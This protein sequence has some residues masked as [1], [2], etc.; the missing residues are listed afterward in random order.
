MADETYQ[1]PPGPPPSYRPQR[2]EPQ[3]EEQY[4]PPPGPPPSQRGA[5]ITF[6]PPARPEPSSN[7]A[8]PS[9]PPPSYAMQSQ[10]LAYDYAP[11]QGPPPSRDD[12]SSK[13]PSEKSSTAEP[14]PYHDWTVIPDTSLL[15]P[16]PSIGYDH[17]PTANAS[18]SEGDAAYAW[19]RANPLWAPRPLAPLQAAAVQRGELTLMR[20]AEFAGDLV[21]IRQRP[22]T[23]RARSRPGCRDACLQSSLPLYPALADAPWRTGAPKTIYFE[24]QILGF[25]DDGGRNSLLRPR[26]EEADAGVAVGFIAPP[27]PTFRLP[28]WQRGS[29]GV[30]GDD[31]RRYVND[32]FGGTDFTTAFKAGQT[33]GIGMSFGVPKVQQGGMDVEV[34]FTRDGRREGGWDLHEELDA[35]VE[36]GVEGLEGLHDI[37]AAVGVFGAAEFEVRFNPRDWMYRPL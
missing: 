10:S 7:Y 11:P 16:P 33:V 6:A 8:P 27:Y 12:K 32:T 26:Q 13:L 2:P 35:R 29:L 14:P 18:R 17:S 4:A 15:P 25:G 36:G 31:G 34:F 22:G 3:G 28:G 5:H 20:P 24:L 21:P 37:F 23:W 1:P 9:G 30:H 19:C